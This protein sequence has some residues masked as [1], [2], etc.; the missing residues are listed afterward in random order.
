MQNSEVRLWGIH[1]GATGDADRLFLK[2]RVVALGWRVVGDLSS[3]DADREAFKARLSQH[4]PDL[5]TRSIANSAGQLYRFIH[6][7]QIED[8]V[9]YP[10]K[11]ERRIHVGKVTGDYEYHPDLESGYPHMKSSKEISVF[12][13]RIHER[14]PLSIRKLIFALVMC[15]LAGH[16][17]AKGAAGYRQTKQPAQFVIM[18]MPTEDDDAIKKVASTFKALDEDIGVGVGM[19]LSYLET[20]PNET[21]RKLKRF[22]STAEQCN[23][24]VVIEMDGINWWQARPDLWN[25][26][27][28]T[29][30]GYDPNNRQNV[31]WTDWTAESAVK[32]GWRNWGRQFRVGPMPNLMSPAYLEACHTEVK[33]LV[34]IIVDWW[35]ALPADKKHLLVAVQMGIE[36]SIGANNWHYPDGNALLQKPEEDD[37]TYGLNHEVLPGRGVQAMGYATVSTLGL[38]SQGELKEAHVTAA[39]SRYL[40]GLCRIASDAGVPRDRLFAHAGGWKEGES[41]YFAALNSYACPGWSFYTHAKDPMADLTAMEAVAKSDAPYWGA[42]EWLLFNVEKQSEWEDALQRFLV[43]PRLRYV[44]VRHWGSIE[45][46]PV[47]I[48]AIQ[49]VVNRRKE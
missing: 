9:A 12:V 46:D 41:V 4:Y 29:K 6:E 20:E 5:G 13:N 47:A 25:W 24:P 21:V 26:W 28:E 49:S 2:H 17:N 39:V 8:L 48:R 23:L 7:M 31:E 42:L 14:C 32:I 38:A 27:D 44:Q 33:R 40:S 43:I 11:Q 15:A 36:C 30:P 19:I 10:S 22:L 35:Q 16:V 45:N 34:P 37:P 3:L 1:A 18:S